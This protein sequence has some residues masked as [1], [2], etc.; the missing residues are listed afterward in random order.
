MA[1]AS[2]LA[3]AAF[4]VG[5]GIVGV[6]GLTIQI[7]QVVVQFG[8]EWKNAPEEAKHFSQELRNLKTVLSETRTNFLDDPTFKEAFQDRKSIVLSELGPD[9]ATATDPKLSIES[10]K[11]ELEKVLDELKKRHDGRRISWERLKGFFLTKSTQDSMDHLR[12]YCQ[13]LND[14]FSMDA[15]ILGVNIHTEVREVRR[16]QKEWHNAGEYQKILTWISTLSFE[17]KQTDILSKRHPGTGEWLLVQD[18]FR[19]WRNDVSDVPSVLWCPGISKLLHA[20][21]LAL[22]TDPSIV[23]AGKSVM[24]YVYYHINHRLSQTCTRLI[25]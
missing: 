6:I 24:T 17:E 18:E 8:L 23:G 10:C 14:M 12:R 2:R 16:E 13:A 21:L 20:S 25:S 5:A 15:L 4:G 1:F 22:M 9:A 19:S 3:M 11:A 7:T